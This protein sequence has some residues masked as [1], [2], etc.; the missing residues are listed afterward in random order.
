M[1]LKIT[2]I[3]ARNEEREC[4]IETNEIVGIT[5]THTK[6]ERLYDENRNVVQ[7]NVLPNTYEIVLKNGLKTVVNEETY[8]KLIAKLNVETL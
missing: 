5:Q 3:N 4:V 2:R 1:L 8:Q 7:E 6:V